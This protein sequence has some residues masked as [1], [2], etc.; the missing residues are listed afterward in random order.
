M[1]KRIQ[2]FQQAP[3]SGAPQQPGQQQQPQQQQPQ[4]Q[5]L[6]RLSTPLKQDNILVSPPPPRSR[7][8]RAEH[9][10]A[11][12]TKAAA[13]SLNQP[14]SSPPSIPNAAKQ[15]VDPARKLLTQGA[16]TL[17]SKESQEKLS[18]LA[19]PQSTVNFYLLQF[20]R[21]PFGAPFRQT[22]AHRSVAVVFGAPYGV[23][24]PLLF[25]ISSLSRLAI[26]SLKEDE[27]GTVS[28]DVP[29]IIRTFTS[30]E[31][32]VTRFLSSLPP[33]WTD[34]EFQDGERAKVKEVESVLEGL[35]AGLEG[36]VN[37]F[38]E[39]ADDLRLSEQEMRMAKEAVA[40]G[41]R[42][43]EEMGEKEKGMG[44][45]KEQDYEKREKQG[46]NGVGGG[47][48]GGGE[49]RQVDGGYAQKR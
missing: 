39:F 8:E 43:G 33:H 24:T 15:L 13:Q 3:L 4:L 1:A 28:K 27:Y 22:F 35:R 45:G 5:G 7:Y 47:G 25:A 21:S 49:G 31:A 14:S 40:R 29:T 44:K 9:Q 2:D 12:T 20:L 10:L 6:P 11:L 36:L 19:H 42:K 18:H 48:G 37:E 34:V 38:G 30:S 16:D 46:G 32:A 23:Q 17:L 26:A 41:R